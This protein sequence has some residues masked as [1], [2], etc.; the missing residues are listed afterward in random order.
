MKP[1]D[2]DLVA[3]FKRLHLANARRT[4]ICC[5]WTDGPCCDRTNK[6]PIPRVGEVPLVLRMGRGRE[7]KRGHR[8]V[9]VRRFCQLTAPSPA[10]PE[11]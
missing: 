6:P 9:A 2:I 3:L 7:S 5:G 4:F 10:S 1:S 8:G 11:P